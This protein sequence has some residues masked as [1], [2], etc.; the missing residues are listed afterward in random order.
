MTV[1]YNEL[2]SLYSLFLILVH[3]IEVFGQIGH[4]E[5]DSKLQSHNVL[6]H[7]LFDDCKVTPQSTHQRPMHR[8]V[9]IQVQRYL[10]VPS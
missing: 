6:E 4:V 3:S 9:R 1:A 5:E 7:E 10:L 8:S 2:F